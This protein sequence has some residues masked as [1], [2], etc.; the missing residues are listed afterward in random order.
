MR[1][2]VKRSEGVAK[3]GENAALREKKIMM[4]FDGCFL[5]FF[6]HAEGE[7]NFWK[8]RQNFWKRRQNNNNTKK[9][10]NKKNRQKYLSVIYLSTHT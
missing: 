10:E 4:K 3:S 9:K 1:A 2:Q 5:G 6:K 7:Q 8:R